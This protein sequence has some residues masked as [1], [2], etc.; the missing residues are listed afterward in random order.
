MPLRGLRDYA[1]WLAIPVCGLSNHFGLNATGLQSLGNSP[2]RG[3]V[4]NNVWANL[5]RRD[6]RHLHRHSSGIPLYDV[7][8][9]VTCY[10]RMASVEEHVL[11]RFAIGNEAADFVDC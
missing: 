5:L 9:S 2:R 10:R 11:A 8:D 3:I 4:A 1:E 7:I 6:R